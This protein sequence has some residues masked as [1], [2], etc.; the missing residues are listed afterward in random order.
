MRVKIEKKLINKMVK[1]FK[2]SKKIFKIGIMIGKRERDLITINDFVYPKQTQGEN[3]TIAE[4]SSD[5]YSNVINKYGKKAIGFIFYMIDNMEACDTDTNSKM[6]ERGAM[7][8]LID[9]SLVITAK[10]KHD[11]FSDRDLDIKIK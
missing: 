1:V 11:F 6:R 2:K 8:G 10:G 3:G 9:L 4:I 7:F 5:E